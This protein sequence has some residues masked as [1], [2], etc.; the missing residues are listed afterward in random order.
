MKALIS[1]NLDGA[2][3]DCDEKG[4]R[5]GAEIARLLEAVAAGIEY[6]G[7]KPGEHVVMNDYNGN[8]VLEFKITKR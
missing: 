1:N 4:M 8:A 5:D 2:A 7:V 3:F 6:R